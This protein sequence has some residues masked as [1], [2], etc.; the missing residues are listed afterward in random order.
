MVAEANARPEL[1]PGPR[2]RRLKHLRMRLRNTAG[3]FEELRE[4]YGKIVYYKLPGR[5]F[6]VVSDP[7]L[8]REILVVKRA[9]FVKTD[10]GKGVMR[11]PTVL[12]GDGD[13][14]TRRRKLMQ[15]AFNKRQTDWFGEVVI[16]NATKRQRLHSSGQTID[17]NKE[18]HLLALDIARE[19]FFE[20]GSLASPEL[21]HGVIDSLK[22]KAAR[23]LLPMGKL[24]SRLPLRVN[25]RV[26]RNLAQMDA[27]FD[28]AIAAARQAGPGQGRDVVSLLVHATDEEGE[29]RSFTD[30][31]VREDA[32]VLLLAGH[33]TTASALAWAFLSLLRHPEALRRLE[34]EVEEVIGQAPLRV[35]DVERLPYARAVFAET[36]RLMPPIHF[37]GRRAIE[38]CVIGGHL[39]PGNTG[40]QCAIRVVHMNDEHFPNA[41]EFRPERWLAERP[42]HPKNAYVPFGSG[43]RI[44]IGR[45]LALVQGPL[46]LASVLQRWRLESAARNGRDKTKS[47]TMFQHDGPLLATLTERG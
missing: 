16:R 23:A 21:I 9:S 27:I 22:W 37:I 19:A 6:C 5:H 4:R 1:P 2:G 8:L 26:H 32:Y 40:V 33:D 24:I 28:A 3:L 47:L 14:H 46:V 39:I 30:E 34:A 41:R 45:E 7:D 31:E 15:P 10:V 43:P 42:S 44:C 12:T 13:E 20:D 18:M 25:L 17:L 36:L 38:D 35:E 11:I 29:E